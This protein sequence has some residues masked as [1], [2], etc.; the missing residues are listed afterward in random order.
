MRTHELAEHAGVNAQT[1]RYYERRGL[2]AEPGRSP[3]GYRDYPADAV[4]V[5]RFIKRAQR[6]GFSLEQVRELLH[7]AGGGMDSG[8]AARALAE[9]HIADLDTKIADLD[10]LRDALRDVTAAPSRRHDDRPLLHAIPN[11]PGVRTVTVSARAGH[12]RR[13]DGVRS[14]HHPGRLGQCPGPSSPSSP[15]GSARW[16]PPPSIHHVTETI[17][18]FDAVA[19]PGQ[20]G[21]AG[22]HC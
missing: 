10:R 11:D 12:R 6:L 20:A 21:G 9:S 19:A 1:L 4:A 16:S 22:G 13:Q 5:V 3:A 8:E 15:G 14:A 7:L 17:Q 2:L 18:T